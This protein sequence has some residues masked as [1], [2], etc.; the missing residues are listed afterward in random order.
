M[1]NIR[2]TQAY[3]DQDRAKSLLE[4]WNPVLDYTSDNVA[5]IEDD[6]TRLNTAMLLENQEAWCLNEATGNVSGGTGSVNT[7]KYRRGIDSRELFNSVDNTSVCDWYDGV[8]GAGVEVTGGYQTLSFGIT[9]ITRVSTLAT[10]TTYGK[11]GLDDGQIVAIAGAG[12]TEYN[13]SVTIAVE[14]PTTFTYDVSGTPSTPAS[15]TITYNENVSVKLTLPFGHTTDDEYAFSSI[16][17]VSDEII[18]GA[19]SAALATVNTGVAFSA[20]GELGNNAS[21]G[22]SAADVGT[23]SIKSVEIQDPGV[24]FT[25]APVISPCIIAISALHIPKNSS[26][27]S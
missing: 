5:P 7:I 24:G 21:V 14:S 20:G 25:S 10:A 12:E 9:S 27:S 6:H 23:G 8:G 13:G 11:H 16:D 2:P 18:T 15:G 4:K 17:F 19:N 3:I 1:K 26:T 22:V